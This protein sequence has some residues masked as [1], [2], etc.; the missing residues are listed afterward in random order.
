MYLEEA[1]KMNPLLRDFSFAENANRFTKNLQQNPFV[2]DYM[3]FI[4]FG[5]GRASDHAS[6][7]VR[8]GY[9]TRDQAVEMVRK[10]DHVKPRRDLDRWLDYV[11]MTEDQ[12]DQIAD[13]FRN[14]RV[15]WIEEGQWWKNDLW[16]GASPYGPVHLTNPD[17][18]GKY[19]RK[20]EVA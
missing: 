10:Y 6:K 19:T 5:Y 3:K 14:P 17:A 15:W 20:Q 8:D 4:K 18:I 2:N 7:D 12:F 13:T 9:L 1:F 16:G 11:D